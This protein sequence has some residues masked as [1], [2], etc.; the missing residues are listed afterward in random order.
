[1]EFNQFENQVTEQREKPNNY[2]GLSITSTVLGLCSFWCIGL[3]LGIIAIVMSSQSTSKYKNGEYEASVKAASTAKKLAL[4]AILL[5]V[6]AIGKAVFDIVSAGGINAYFET[7]ME[8]V[9]AA[10]NM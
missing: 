10:Q 8:Q 3:I 1:M 7:I 9:R 6:I 2:M 5:F 4:V